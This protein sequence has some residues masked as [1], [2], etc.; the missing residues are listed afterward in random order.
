MQATEI[1]MVHKYMVVYV[2][3]GITAKV[4]RSELQ[5]TLVPMGHI[6]PSQVERHS[7]LASNVMVVRFVMDKVYRNQTECVLLGFIASQVRENQHL[8]MASLETF[9]L[10][11]IIAQE[12]H[13]IHYNAWLE[14]TGTFNAVLKCAHSLFIFVLDEDAM[15]IEL[16]L[17]CSSFPSSSSLFLYSVMLYALQYSSLFLSVLC[18]AL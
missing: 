17:P 10:L 16:C 3:R 2:P 4:E 9:A 13:L 14:L 12:I 5:I 8:L 7:V 11:D 15:F 6:T 1:S 18:P